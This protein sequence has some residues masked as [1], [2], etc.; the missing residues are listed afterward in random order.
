MFHLLL[1]VQ[2]LAYTIRYSQ[3]KIKSLKKKNLLKRKILTIKRC[4]H[5]ADKTHYSNR[6][7]WRHFFLI[8]I[9]W[10]VRL[11]NRQH[12]LILSYCVQLQQLVVGVFVGLD[13]RIP[14]EYRLLMKK[15]LIFKLCRNQQ[16]QQQMELVLWDVEFNSRFRLH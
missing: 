3:V 4:V 10:T 12:A 9:Q 13:F 11:P 8:K 15:K 5:C 7:T 2:F 1:F 6:L 14:A 16:Q